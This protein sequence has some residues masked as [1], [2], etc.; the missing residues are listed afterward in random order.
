MIGNR[1]NTNKLVVK[2]LFILITSVLFLDAIYNIRVEGVSRTIPL[3]LQ[4]CILIICL[5]Y[6]MKD[7]LIII[8]NGKVRS[9]FHFFLI[10][11]IIIISIYAFFSSNL[12]KLPVLLLGIS[13][14]FVFYDSALSQ[15]ISQKSLSFFTIL[16]LSIF[17]YQTYDGIIYR[18]NNFSNFLNHADNTGY[19]LV[20]WMLIRMLFKK[21]LFNFILITFA[22]IL[23][24]ISLKRGAIIIASIIFIVNTLPY[25]FGSLNLNKI[26]II[27]IRFISFSIILYLFFQLINF[28]DIIFGRFTTI[29]DDGGSSRFDF[30]SLIINSWYNSD[31][32]NLIF[33][34]GFFSVSE[35]LL[36]LNVTGL[37]TTYAHSDIQIIYD[38]GI[39]GLILYVLLFI[40]LLFN[41]KHVKKNLNKNHYNIF[42]LLII[43]WLF[44]ATY[45][46]IYLTKDSLLL[47]TMIGILL[48]KSK[49]NQLRN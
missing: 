41:Y 39:F 13:P 25:L 36:G 33:G 35:L 27:F 16:T 45:S 29:L 3:L 49:A 8:V 31:I 37:E 5:I 9:Y 1:L 23:I 19:L 21:S 30:Y 43:T 28:Y 6:F 17:T 4:S 44:K 24:L 2:F 46:G 20:S 38:H 34:H 7:L 47:F 12:K 32:I 22:Y 26:Q 48:G 15:N 40:S 18:I 10:S 14:F 42:L 11:F